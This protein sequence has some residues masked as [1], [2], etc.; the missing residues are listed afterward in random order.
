MY[1]MTRKLNFNL[2]INIPSNVWM[3]LLV[4]ILVLVVMNRCNKEGFGFSLEDSGFSE[5]DS[6]L[7]DTELLENQYAKFENNVCGPINPDKPFFDTTNF[8]PKCCK[9]IGQYSNS[10]GCPCMCP[11]QL[12]YLNHR[13]GNRSEPS[14]Y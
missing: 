13:G 10:A 6:H 8:D 1:N 3:I 9:E 5:L 14:Q 11:E 2:N 7:T 4:V 12:K